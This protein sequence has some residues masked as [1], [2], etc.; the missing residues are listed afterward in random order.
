MTATDVRSTANTDQPRL[1]QPVGPL[2]LGGVFVFAVVAAFLLPQWGVLTP[3]TKPELYLNPAGMLG[4]E[5]SAWRP[6]PFLGSPNY[7]PGI[8]PIT[9]VVWGLQQIGL[10]PWA[11]QRVLAI[12]LTLLASAGAWFLV[13]RLTG[14]S[15][16]VPVVA[17]IAYAI[18]PYA[19]VAGATLPIRLPHAVL[20]WFVL[21]AVLALRG[22]G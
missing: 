1:G 17:G 2:I 19:V 13:R 4:R 8:A 18:H 15:G 3:D 16:M 21:A 11:S 5:L 12:V 9:A 10:A 6:G 7:H 14:R 20:P 22:G